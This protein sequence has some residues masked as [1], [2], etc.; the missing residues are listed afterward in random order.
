[1]EPSFIVPDISAHFDLWTRVW[2]ESMEKFRA[3]HPGREMCS[4]GSKFRSQCLNAY[5]N[6]ALSLHYGNTGPVRWTEDHHGVKFLFI[7]RERGDDLAVRF[8]ILD[9]SL[10]TSNHSSAHQDAI[11]QNGLMLMDKATHAQALHLICGIQ[12]EESLAG[13][14]WIKRTVLTHE[15]AEL[16]TVIVKLYDAND[17][18]GGVLVGPDEPDLLPP[19]PLIKL[20]VPKDETIKETKANPDTDPNKKTAADT[21]ADKK[22]GGA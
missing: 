16:V 9:Q 15:T 4:L 19:L 12:V 8:K 11:R 21:D 14:V 3:R 10:R 18:D 6:D 22:I 7:E 1:M 20:R 13:E 2:K 5:A 17:L